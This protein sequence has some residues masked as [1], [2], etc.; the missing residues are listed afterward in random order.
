MTY[1]DLYHSR[2]RLYTEYA[3]APVQ[4]PPFEAFSCEGDSGTI[5]GVRSPFSDFTEDPMSVVS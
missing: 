2:H 3:A 4:K 5:R 1:R